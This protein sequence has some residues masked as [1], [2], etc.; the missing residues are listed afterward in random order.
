[1]PIEANLPLVFREKNSLF[2]NSTRPCHTRFKCKC[3]IKHI[4]F[5]THLSISF[6]HPQNM[7]HQWES[8]SCTSSMCGMK[9]TLPVMVSSRYL[10]RWLI[11]TFTSGALESNISNTCAKHIED[12]KVGARD[13]ETYQI[14]QTAVCILHQPTKVIWTTSI[15]EPSWIETINVPKCPKHN[16]RRMDHGLKCRSNHGKFIVLLSKKTFT[17]HSG[18]HQ[19]ITIGSGHL[20]TKGS[21]AGDRGTQ[22]TRLVNIMRHTTITQSH[23]CESF[24]F[25]VQ[26]N[27]SLHAASAKQEA[28]SLHINDCEENWRQECRH[29]LSRSTST[30]VQ[31]W[32]RLQAWRTVSVKSWNIDHNGAWNIMELRATRSRER[33]VE[34]WWSESS[35]SHEHWW[36]TI[37]LVIRW[38]NKT[39][40]ASEWGGIGI[41][42]DGTAQHSCK[43]EKHSTDGPARFSSEEGDLEPVHSATDCGLHFRRRGFQ[44]NGDEQQFPK[45]TRFHTVRATTSANTDRTQRCTQYAGI[46]GLE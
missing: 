36:R 41:L 30:R 32:K 17:R 22:L 23:S 27:L 25:H 1:M 21:F 35:S 7:E 19:S 46:P 34:Y 4:T 6:S 16:H 37:H 38:S 39:L 33:S 44:P 14:H 40:S 11:H 42:H 12:R 5:T 28:S 10:A 9:K 31:S 29:G 45:N 26:E 13:L 43:M 3:P 24:S 2:D 8:R 18:A 20:G 15:M